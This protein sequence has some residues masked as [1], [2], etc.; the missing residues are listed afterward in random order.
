VAELT[1]EERVSEI[2]RMMGQSDTATTAR[3]NAAEMLAEATQTRERVR[4]ASGQ[5]LRL[6]ER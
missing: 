4:G 1:D 6:T 5:Q 3:S 2:A